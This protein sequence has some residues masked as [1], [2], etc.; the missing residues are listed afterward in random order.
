MVALAGHFGYGPRMFA[1][2][3]HVMKHRASILSLRAL[4]L[5]SGP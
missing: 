1:A 3:I 2:S 5:L 4:L